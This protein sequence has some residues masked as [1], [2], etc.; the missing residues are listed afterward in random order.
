RTGVGRAGSALQG[1]ADRFTLSGRN[2]WCAR[3]CSALRRGGREAA[4]VAALPGPAAGE[5]TGAISDRGANHSLARTAEAIA[6]HFGAALQFTSPIR[7]S[8]RGRAVTIGLIVVRPS[9]VSPKWLVF[10]GNGF[11]VQ[12]RRERRAYPEVD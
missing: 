5:I 6:P 1:F 4:E 7:A 10:C 2:D 3:L 12:A 11:S 8:G 9:V